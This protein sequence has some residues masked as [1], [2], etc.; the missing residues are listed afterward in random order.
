LWLFSFENLFQKIIIN[1]LDLENLK[2]ISVIAFPLALSISGLFQFFLLFSFLKKKISLKLNEIKN[3]LKKILFSSFL[4]A[5]SVYFVLKISAIFLNLQTF[6][7][8]FFQLILA[9]FAGFLIY[10]LSTLS[11]KSPELKSLK[12]LRRIEIRKK[13]KS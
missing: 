1:F 3:S 6:W 13:I 7:G 5:I 12:G 8:I 4:M 10:F 9:S 2:N 11:L